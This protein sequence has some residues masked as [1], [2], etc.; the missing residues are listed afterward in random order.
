[1]S[2]DNRYMHVSKKVEAFIGPRSVDVMYER[3][4]EYV[5]CKCGNKGNAMREHT[6]VVVV[7]QD[8]A[9]PRLAQAHMRCMS[10][11]VVK[12][13]GRGNGW[14][15]PDPHGDG[16][17]DVVSIPA[18]WPN[19][20]GTEYHAGLLIDMQ[21]GDVAIVHAESGETE[22]PVVSGF[23]RMGWDLVLDIYQDLVVLDDYAVN[24]TE[25]RTG[26]VTG[27]GPD[28]EPMMLL[29]HLP[30]PD[31]VWIAHALRDGYVR[32]LLGNLGLAGAA[33]GRPEPTII[34]AVRA[35]KVVGARIP[36]RSMP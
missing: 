19:R 9:Y 4:G 13:P 7:T 1:M 31:P 2:R 36:V 11:Q 16:T 33:P 5:C 26:S 18:I 8:N 28:G 29:D 22:D 35:A 6:S 21:S 32:V 25:G 15:P 23:A 3:A 12:L 10:S 27:V 30:Q 34:A 20:A 14:T 24:L 17:N